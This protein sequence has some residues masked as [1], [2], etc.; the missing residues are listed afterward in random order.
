MHKAQW[1][2][3][4]RNVIKI[5][6]KS[7]KS[8]LCEGLSK[9]SV[10]GWHLTITATPRQA[11]EWLKIFVN[12]YFCVPVSCI[13]H[14]GPVVPHGDAVWSGKKENQALFSTLPVTCLM[15]LA[16]SLNLNNSAHRSQIPITH[17]SIHGRESPR[18][19]QG[20]T[21][22]CTGMAEIFTSELTSCFCIPL[23]LCWCLDP[24]FTPGAENKNRKVRSWFQGKA[25]TEIFVSR[26]PGCSQDLCQVY[27]WRRRNHFLR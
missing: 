27:K 6:E 17:F 3:W 12:G 16:R 13:S 21:P 23:Q 9:V 22:I 7:L 15:I 19:N 20:I 11:W 10:P 18:R 14:T 5:W 25:Q 24:T 8:Q 1:V 4:H 2:V 26:V